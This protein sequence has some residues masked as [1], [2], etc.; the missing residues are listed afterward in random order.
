M[1]DITM[2]RDSQCPSNNSCY[3]YIATPSPGKEQSY[4]FPPRNDSDLKC[5]YFMK[6][7]CCQLSLHQHGSIGEGERHECMFCNKGWVWK[8]G[9]WEVLMGL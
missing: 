3:R 5:D 7:T 9:G 2:C 8:A 4:F 1:P 6:S